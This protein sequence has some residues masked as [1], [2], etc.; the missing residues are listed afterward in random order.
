M[1]QRQNSRKIILHGFYLFGNVALIKSEVN[2]AGVAGGEGNRPLQGQSPYIINAGVQ[3]NDSKY[4]FG[5]SFSYNRIGQRI[6]SVGFDTYPSF[7]ETPRNVLDFQVTK[8]FWKK[9]ELKFNARDIL[10]NPTIWYQN[11]NAKTRFDAG[12]NE[13]M[14]VIPGATYSFSIGFNL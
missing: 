9:L 3:Y 12:D 2:L 14:R 1:V 4:D 8:T 10:A 13:I 5:V 7:W 6:V 11:N